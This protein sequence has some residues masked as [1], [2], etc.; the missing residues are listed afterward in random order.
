MN[1]NTS[2]DETLDALAADLKKER[3]VLITC[4][5]KP[6]GDALGC[7]IAMHRAMSCLGADIVMY[8][9]D[10]RPITPEY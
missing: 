2:M 1:D 10:D 6:D 7:L 5:V 4:H 9:A 3:R 8:M